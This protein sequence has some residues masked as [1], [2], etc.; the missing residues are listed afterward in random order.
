MVRSAKHWVFTLN[1]Y[2]DQE[3]ANLKNEQERVKYF[4]MGREVGASGTPHLQGFISFNKRE[5]A[6]S[7]KSIVG[8]RAHVEIAKGTPEQA[9]TYCKKD[10]DFFEYGT[11]PVGRGKRSDLDVIFE[12][13]KA[14]ATRDEIRDEFFKTYARYYRAIDALIS[15]CQSLRDWQTEVIVYWGKT[16]TGKTRQVFEFHDRAD[17][18]IHPGDHWFDGYTGQPV[19]LFDDFCGSEFKLTYLLKLLDRYPMKVPIKGGF[20][21][22]IPKKI[23]ITSNKNPDDWYP[24]AY[25]EHRNALKRRLSV[26]TEFK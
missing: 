8:S 6:R 4:V 15:D 14:G 18:Y 9:A 23:F 2:T 10:G 21:N 12:R 24:C 22:W 17:I 7:V 19:A 11:V 1:N 25:S 16:G 3:F 13:V 5:T 20:V 26:I